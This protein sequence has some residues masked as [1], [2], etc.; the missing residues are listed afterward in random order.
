MSE[1]FRN[2]A[3]ALRKISNS[4]RWLYV[5][6]LHICLAALLFAKE[7]IM[8]ILKIGRGELSYLE[9]FYLIPLF[10]LVYLFA[11]QYR[12]FTTIISFHKKNW[13]V[14]SAGIIMAVVNL[15]LNLIFVPRFGRI[16][17]VIATVFSTVIYTI[18][19]TAWAKKYD[20]FE[21]SYP[22]YIISSVV[23]GI[24]AVIFVRPFRFLLDDISITNIFT[25]VLFYLILSGVIVIFR[26]H[27]VKKKN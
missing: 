16:S 3:L 20:D 6:M 15:S 10:S 11:S 1:M 2:K 25:K 14:S 12:M 23:Y 18:W 26:R 17:A 9:G 7:A 24:L 13:V 27:W 5:F 19:I 8:L 4:S 21:I 22:W